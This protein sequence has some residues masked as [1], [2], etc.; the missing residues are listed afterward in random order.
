MKQDGRASLSNMF[1]LVESNSEVET[2]L[3]K[4]CFCV[5]K[6]YSCSLVC[7]VMCRDT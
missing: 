5:K 2:Y 6:S 7:F 3:I 1:F 4:F